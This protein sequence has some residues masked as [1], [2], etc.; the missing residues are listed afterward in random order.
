MLCAGGVECDSANVAKFLKEMEG[1]NLDELLAA[2]REK[3][4]SMPAAG[5]APAGGGGGGG[6]GA[7]APAAEEKKVEEESEEEVRAPA[8]H[9]FR[10]AMRLVWQRSR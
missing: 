2:G 1:K 4:A 8:L 7:A 9:A 5:A 10:C 6:G 3:L